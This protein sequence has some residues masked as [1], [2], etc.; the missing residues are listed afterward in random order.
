MPKGRQLAAMG[1]D[2]VYLEDRE[3]KFS[4]L[5][6]AASPSFFHFT[7][8]K[9]PPPPLLNTLTYSPPRTKSKSYKHSK[10]LLFQ[11]YRLSIIKLFL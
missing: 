4:S 2:G 7:P 11:I 6:R 5:S 1:R 9:Q 10:Y 8:V 3:D